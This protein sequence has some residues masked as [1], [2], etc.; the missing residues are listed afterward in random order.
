MNTS[1]AAYEPLADGLLYPSASNLLLLT[2]CINVISLFL[3]L[4]FHIFEK[5]NL[6][7]APQLR[8][9]VSLNIFVA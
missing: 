7:A 5:K 8:H 3:F 2:G 6:L 9:L 4:V 1:L